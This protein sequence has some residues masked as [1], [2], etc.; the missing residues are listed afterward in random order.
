L[1]LKGRWFGLALAIL[2]S[3]ILLIW[4][5]ERAQDCARAIETMFQ[6]PVKVVPTLQ[7][8]SKALQAEEFSAVL[9]DQWITEAEPGQAD[10]LIHHLGGAIPVFVNFGISG[11]E[12]ILRELRAAFHRRGRETVLAQQNARILLWNSL[13][14][15]VTALLLCCG[16]ILD[17]PALDRGVA[18]RVKTIEA[19]ANRIKEKLAA[20]ETMSAGSAGA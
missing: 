16:V 9:V 17:D 19:V 20:E 7:R 18:V 6:Q 10:Y 5:S 15:D 12:R 4:A 11:I 14:D 3:M 1:I 2:Q 13:K 8:A